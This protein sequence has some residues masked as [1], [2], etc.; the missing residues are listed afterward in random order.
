MQ[1]KKVYYQ[2]V[3]DRTPFYGESGGQVGDSGYIANEGEKL[4]IFDT[5]KENN[6]TVHLTEKLPVNPD[7]SFTAVVDR[8][9]RTKTANN[10][11]ATHLLH[12]ALR[13]VLGNHVE[14]KGSLVDAEHLRFDFSHF[15]KMTDEE[16]KKVESIVN[17]KIRENTP[18]EENREIPMQQAREMNAVMLFGEK[19]G[20]IVRVIK[21]GD[22][23]ELCGGTHVK[24]TGQIGLFKIVS[25]SAIAAG[26]RRIEAITGKKAEN[27]VNEQLEIL[28]NIKDTVKGSKNIFDSVKDLVDKNAELS[29]K[30]E[31]FNL[32]RLKSIRNDLKGSIITKNGINVISGIVNVENA[33]MMKDLAF[34]LRG[35]VDNLFLALGAEI[36][37]KPNLTVM[38]SDNIVKQKGLNAARIVNEAGR[39]IKG[40]GGGQDFYATAG[41]RDIKGLQ[42]ALEK[43]LSCLIV[44]RV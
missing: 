15:K 44:D 37:G 11:T 9:N 33:A 23:I 43:V 8:E 5:R 14:Q 27:Y 7:K 38:I 17:D 1:K 18:L 28:K 39:E 19:Y 32:E 12:A 20:D 6:L 13:Q 40:G 41:G 21:F 24:S 16:I 36:G 22:S 25:E 3:F 34:S 42:S 10:H 35:E 30:I 26:V 4:Y 31:A 2:L 29:G